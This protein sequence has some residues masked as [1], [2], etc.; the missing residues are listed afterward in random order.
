MMKNIKK[1]LFDIKTAIESIESYVKDIDNFETYQ[2]NKLIRRAVER[3]IEIIGEATNKLLKIDESI[4]IKHAR[5][6]VDTRNWVI[7]G[8]DNVDDMIIWGVITKYLPRLKVD[9]DKLLD[10]E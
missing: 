3:E 9:I 5:N 8:Y 1:Y 4:Q 6:I 7:H 2:G 10:N